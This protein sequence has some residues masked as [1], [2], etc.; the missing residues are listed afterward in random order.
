MKKNYRINWGR[1]IPGIQNT[2]RRM[3]LT[4]F[5][6]AFS[7]ITGFAGNPYPQTK[8]PNLV[9][10]NDVKKEV[11]QD[12]EVIQEKIVTG[13]II[14]DAGETIPGVSVIIKGTS[15]GT[16][17]DLDGKYSIK[18]PDNNTVLIFS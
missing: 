14:D 12:T 8:K 13:T 1:E 16:V 15:Q 4:V 18:V 3:N 7:V 5:L 17:T 6:M 11:L 9:F 10:N 2:I